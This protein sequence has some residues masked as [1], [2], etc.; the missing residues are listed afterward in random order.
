MHPDCVDNI[1]ATGK[2][3]QTITR[4][5]AVSNSSLPLYYSG[6]DASAM[7]A[8]GVHSAVETVDLALC[9]GQ[10]RLSAQVPS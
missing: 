4:S 10:T 9:L 3:Y 8:I 6:T 7:H 2:F 5:P 1:S